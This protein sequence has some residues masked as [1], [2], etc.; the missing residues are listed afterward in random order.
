MNSI[1]SD[2]NK[3]GYIPI[4]SPA[5]KFADL[6]FS[7]RRL[8]KGNFDK[9]DI[10]PLTDIDAVKN[11]VK[12]IIQTQAH[13]KLFNFEFGSGV[14][15]LLFEN[16]NPF[17]AIA[18]KREIE[19]SISKYE[20]RV[21]QVTVDISDNSERNSYTISMTFNIS[22]FRQETIQFILNRLR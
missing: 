16:V 2:Y 10:V 13:E 20:P 11:S 4:I 15:G 8:K 6:D 12:N 22:N 1:L 18:L 7:L 21:S 5:T 17:T 9:G 3:S 14:R 19:Q